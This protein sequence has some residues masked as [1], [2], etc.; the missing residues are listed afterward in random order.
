M[1]TIETFLENKNKLTSEISKAIKDKNNAY[2]RQR[3]KTSERKS[4]ISEFINSELKKEIKE[5]AEKN[6]YGHTFDYED[7]VKYTSQ[8]IASPYARIYIPYFS[9]KQSGWFCFFQDGKQPHL[10]H[11]YTI[12]WRYRLYPEKSKSS[13]ETER[14]LRKKFRFV[15]VKT[16]DMQKIKDELRSALINNKLDPSDLSSL[17][18]DYS[19]YYKDK[20]YND[21]Y[22]KAYSILTKNNLNST[23]SSAF[24]YD[25]VKVT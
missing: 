1:Y 10:Y 11:E 4:L 2:A 22:N 12:S 9:M 14:T 20:N 18:Y 25:F 16:I 5:F 8:N 3:L 21:L 7:H 6:N 24:I 17:C 19:R 13:E 15:H 23:L